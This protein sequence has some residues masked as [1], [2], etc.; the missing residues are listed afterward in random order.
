L[1]RQIEDDAAAALD[2]GTVDRRFRR[3]NDIGHIPQRDA[4]ASLKELV[5]I[6]RKSSHIRM[7]LIASAQEICLGLETNTV[8]MC[9]IVLRI[10]ERRGTRPQ[11][12]SL[13]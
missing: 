11:P 9:N 13:D 3:V 8:E 1:F 4:R 2:C 12:R 7:R 6:F 5:S 10:P